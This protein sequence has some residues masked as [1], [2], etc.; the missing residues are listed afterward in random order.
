M[1][2]DARGQPDRASSDSQ[3]EIRMANEMKHRAQGKKQRLQP[4]SLPAPLG[5]SPSPLQGLLRA[6]R[7]FK[8]GPRDGHLFK[9]PQLQTGLTVCLK[10][11]YAL[12]PNE[13]RIKQMF[14]CLAELG[15]KTASSLP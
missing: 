4:P 5:R 14:N 6:G 3:W 7:T 10:V 2:G 15:S 11:M 1:V 12:E 8:Y 9:S 13:D